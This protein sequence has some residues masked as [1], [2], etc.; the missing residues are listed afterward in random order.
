MILNEAEFEAALTVNDNP[1]VLKGLLVGMTNGATTVW[2]ARRD[3][4]SVV[5][6]TNS[7]GTFA[8]KLD[9]AQLFAD[10]LLEMG[11]VEQIELAGLIRTSVDQAVAFG[12]T[13][14]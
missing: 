9:R 12:A 8:F 13:I 7:A 3:K 5:C 4:L 14:Q 11:G 2:S 6:L 1:G 10:L